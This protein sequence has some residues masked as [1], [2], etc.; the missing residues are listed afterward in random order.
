MGGGKGIGG[1]SST[2]KTQTPE[3]TTGS[4]DHVTKPNGHCSG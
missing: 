2:L 3:L 1:K 4:P